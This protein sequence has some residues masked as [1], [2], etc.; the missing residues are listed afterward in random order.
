MQYINPSQHAV[1]TDGIYYLSQGLFDTDH[2]SHT[3]FMRFRDDFTEYCVD[4]NIA[5]MWADGVFASIDDKWKLDGTVASFTAYM[6][7]FARNINPENAALIF[8]FI[9]RTVLDIRESYNLDS[10]PTRFADTSLA[11][12]FTA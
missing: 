10:I 6:E 1:V 8:S 5:P 12:A 7:P 3:L 2:V 9:R 11:S 4:R